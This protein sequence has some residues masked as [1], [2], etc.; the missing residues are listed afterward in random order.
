MRICGE[1]SAEISCET[2]GI[3]NEIAG[4]NSKIIAEGIREDVRDS[5]ETVGG[6]FNK[7]I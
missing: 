2:V 4:E 5:Q 6:I 7:T 3:S 1:H